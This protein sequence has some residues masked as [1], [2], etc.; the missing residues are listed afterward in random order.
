MNSNWITKWKSKGLSNESLEVVSATSNTLTPTVNYYGEKVELRFTRSV[1][2][3]K[4][5]TYSHKKLV[6][7]YVVC[8]ITNFHDIDSYPTL[9]NALFGA[10]KLT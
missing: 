8:E 6:N 4:T 10:I 1:L 5:V 9:T 2:Q 7:L 3:Q